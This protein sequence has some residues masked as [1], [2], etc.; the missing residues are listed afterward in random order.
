MSLHENPRDYADY[1]RYL[2]LIAQITEDWGKAVNSM[3]N[4]M[5]KGRDQQEAEQ[6]LSSITHMISPINELS[7]LLSIEVEVDTK[8]DRGTPGV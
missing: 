1:I 4:F 8:S 5:N 3:N 2:E 7:A 6:A